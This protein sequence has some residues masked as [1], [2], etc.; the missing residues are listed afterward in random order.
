MFDFYFASICL[1]LFDSFGSSCTFAHGLRELRAVLRHP[2]YKTDLCRVYHGT[3][4]CQY[5][6]RCH[7]VHDPEEAAK[8]SAKRGHRLNTSADGE[9]TAMFGLLENPN[10]YCSVYDKDWVLSNLQH[11]HAYKLMEEKNGFLNTSGYSSDHLDSIGTLSPRS[12]SVSL[13]MLTIGQDNLLSMASNSQPLRYTCGAQFDLSGTDAAKHCINTKSPGGG[14]S[15]IWRLPLHCGNWLE[16]EAELCTQSLVSDMNGMNSAPGSDM[17][18]L[19]GVSRER[20]SVIENPMEVSR[21]LF[22]PSISEL[23]HMP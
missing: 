5:G 7:F 3:G 21:N 6:A 12:N 4:F 23:V 22:L 8:A 13:D 1:Y 14:N 2:R 16:R 18:S 17:L 20:K 19:S 9:N 10:T 15:Q 11:L